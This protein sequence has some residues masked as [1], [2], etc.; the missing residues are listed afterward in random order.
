[1]IFISIFLPAILLKIEKFVEIFRKKIKK[2]F[3]IKKSPQCDTIY[4][5]I[6]VFSFFMRCFNIFK[7][8]LYA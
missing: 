8:S 2:I 5:C 6:N 1:M 7:L 3:H 4:K